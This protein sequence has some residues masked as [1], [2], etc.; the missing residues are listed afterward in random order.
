MG[1]STDLTCAPHRRGS[2]VGP[3]DRINLI[4]RCRREGSNPQPHASTGRMQGNP[5]TG[6]QPYSCQGIPQH[7]TYPSRDSTGLGP[8]W[9][10]GTRP[11]FFFFSKPGGLSEWAGRPALAVLLGWADLTVFFLS[12]LFSFIT[13]DFDIQFEPNKF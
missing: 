3:A 2:H 6:L 4:K 10:S 1:P 13:F 11:F 8:S 9:E 7:T 12:F 5:T